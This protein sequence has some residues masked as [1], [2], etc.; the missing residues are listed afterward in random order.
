MV[1]SFRVDVEETADRPEVGR[2]ANVS[3][4]E[5][6]VLSMMTGPA[7]VVGASGSPG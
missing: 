1:L 7:A 4:Y 3:D 2:S 6:G 5:P